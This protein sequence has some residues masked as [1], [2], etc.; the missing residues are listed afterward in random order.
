MEDTMRTATPED[1]KLA[2]DALYVFQLM[3]PDVMQGREFTRDEWEHLVAEAPDSLI[4]TLVDGLQV[5]LV[6]SHA[7]ARTN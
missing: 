4:I 5:A 7:I 3:I 6:R 2:T 1:R